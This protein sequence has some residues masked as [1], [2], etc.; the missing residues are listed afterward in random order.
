MCVFLGYKYGYVPLNILPKI[1]LN[2]NWVENSIG[3]EYKGAGGRVRREE[4]CFLADNE[5]PSF[6]REDQ[7][8]VSTKQK[9]HKRGPPVG[10]V[11]ATPAPSSPFCSGVAPPLRGMPSPPQADVSMWSPSPTFR[12]FWE[13]RRWSFIWWEAPKH[14][15][16][17]GARKCVRFL[18]GP[19]LGSD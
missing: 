11:F 7:Q 15:R 19:E 10:A 5:L 18:A 3:S 17:R 8:L 1:A 4:F 12:V 14:P 9:R 2:Y 13:S 16:G 6:G